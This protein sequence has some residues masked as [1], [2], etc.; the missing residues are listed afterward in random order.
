MVDDVRE[1]DLLKVYL[2]PR[3]MWSNGS[4]TFSNVTPEAVLITV[5]KLE[6]DYRERIK[7]LEMK[8][9]ELREELNETDLGEVTRDA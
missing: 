5:T 9:E 8:V 3:T 2:Q 6:P 1:V 4:Y 7:A